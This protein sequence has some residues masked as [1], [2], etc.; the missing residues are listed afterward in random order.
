MLR[1]LTA[2]SWASPGVLA[3]FFQ[4]GLSPDLH[5]LLLLQL[6]Q[7]LAEALLSAAEPQRSCALP[8]IGLYVP[9]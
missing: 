7:P 4:F 8:F 3:G 9:L 5:S 6:L 1:C 2:I